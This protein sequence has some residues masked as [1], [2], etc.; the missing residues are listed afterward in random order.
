MSY[1]PALVTTQHHMFPSLTRALPAVQDAER[2][3]WL[4]GLYPFWSRQTPPMIRAS[5]PHATAATNLR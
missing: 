3:G 5:D 1:C 2:L 4:D